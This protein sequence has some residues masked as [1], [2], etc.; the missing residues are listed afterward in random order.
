MLVIGALLVISFALLLFGRI[1]KTRSICAA[2]LVLSGAVWSTAYFFGW[3]NDTASSVLGVLMGFPL[4]SFLITNLIARPV[5][6]RRVISPCI[7]VRIIRSGIAY[8]ALILLVALGIF[9]L[10]TGSLRSFGM[11]V[12]AGLVTTSVIIYLILDL[13]E[14]TEIWGNGVWQN[15]SLQ[16]WEDYKCFSWKHETEESIELRLEPKSWI[17]GSTRLTVPFEDR[18]AVLQLLEANLPD[19]SV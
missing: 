10:V 1:A 3:R 15:G 7:P 4:I 14:K 17:G 11:T 19:L 5:L 16:A 13:I 2:F 18:Q 9:L 8:I 6:R 12:F